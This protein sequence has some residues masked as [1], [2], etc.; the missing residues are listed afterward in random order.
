MRSRDVAPDLEK[1]DYSQF[2]NPMSAL[3]K[4]LGGLKYPVP[5][6]DRG[7]RVVLAIAPC[8]ALIAAALFWG[9]AAPFLLTFA[10]AFASVQLVKPYRRWSQLARNHLMEA[11]R[12]HASALA[13]A[14]VKIKFFR[15]AI[16][17]EGLQPIGYSRAAFLRARL[18]F[19]RLARRWRRS[20]RDLSGRIVMPS[21]AE[22]DPASVPVWCCPRRSGFGYSEFVLRG[23]TVPRRIGRLALGIAPL[24]A[25]F[26]VVSAS[27]SRLVVAFRRWRAEA[28]LTRLGKELIRATADECGDVTVRTMARQLGLNYKAPNIKFGWVQHQYPADTPAQ[29]DSE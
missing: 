14:K 11:R 16:F 4:A 12:Q 22:P 27:N 13:W 24:L 26:I 19:P 29:H 10:G 25:S 5:T 1:A 28:L 8:T 17:Y 23:S 2:E 21:R 3:A 15:S 18:R 6:S 7:V 20:F 9:S